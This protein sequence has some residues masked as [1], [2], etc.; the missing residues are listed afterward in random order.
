MIRTGAVSQDHRA[1]L[2]RGGTGKEQ[3]SANYSADPSCDLIENALDGLGQ[4]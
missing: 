4:C 2:A 3:V 1:I